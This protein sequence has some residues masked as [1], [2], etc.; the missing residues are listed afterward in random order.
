M[1]LRLSARTLLLLMIAGVVLAV[2]AA[3]PHRAHA[4]MNPAPPSTT[5]SPQSSPLNSAP[6]STGNGASTGALVNPLNNIKTLPD[7]INVI[8]QGIVQVAGIAL[9]VA[10]MIIGF[11]FVS[12]QG[13]PEELKKARTALMWTL[14]G[15]LILLGAAAISELVRSTVSSL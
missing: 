12:A 11:R 4:Q 3:L 14:I 8:I 9:T 10:L 2:P 7:L 5:Q 1:T 6:P 15:G 13:K